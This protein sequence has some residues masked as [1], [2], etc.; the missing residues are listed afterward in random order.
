MMIPKGSML[1]IQ[2]ASSDDYLLI[3][4]T[5]EDGELFVSGVDAEAE[6]DAAPILLT[7]ETAAQLRDALTEWLEGCNHG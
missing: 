2:C 3:D 1:K 4:D 5:F 6:H 7:P